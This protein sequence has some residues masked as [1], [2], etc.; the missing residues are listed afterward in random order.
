[1]RLR[2]VAAKTVLKYNQRALRTTERV[3]KPDSVGLNER[4]DPLRSPSSLPAG[5]NTRISFTFY[6]FVCFC[7]SSAFLLSGRGLVLFQ[8]EDGTTHTADLEPGKVTYVPPFWAH[9]SVNI[10]DVPLVFLWTCSVEAGHDY[11]ALGGAGM[12]EVVVER[13]GV[14]SVEGRV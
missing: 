8:R 2:N 7:H 13:N 6:R 9:R 10:S 5:A 1:L 4:H 3:I 12:R 14:P 11:E